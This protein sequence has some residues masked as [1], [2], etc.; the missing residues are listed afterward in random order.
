MSD[1]KIE[2]HDRFQSHVAT[3]LGALREGQNSVVRE[4]K[5]MNGSV[6]DLTKRVTTVEKGLATHPL[7]CPIKVD[8]NVLRNDVRKDVSNLKSVVNSHVVEIDTK[9]AVNKKWWDR[10]WPIIKFFIYGIV[11]LF[12]LHADNL[13]E[14]MK[15]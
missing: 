4:L 8:L 1:N 10:A 9:S 12:L 11:L 15:L 3:E 14:K 6:Q 2:F 5:R 13:L 7:E